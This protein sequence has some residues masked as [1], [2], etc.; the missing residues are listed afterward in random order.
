MLPYK[1]HAKKVGFSKELQA[2]NKFNL[3][4]GQAI[5]KTLFHSIGG[6]K[7]ECTRAF[8][9]TLINLLSGY[10][11]I[12]QIWVV[13]EEQP[14]PLHSGSLDLILNPN[15]D[16]TGEQSESGMGPFGIL[17][18]AREKGDIFGPAS[19]IRFTI[20]ILIALRDSFFIAENNKLFLYEYKESKGNLI[21]TN[22][23]PELPAGDHVITGDHPFGFESDISDDEVRTQFATLM[24]IPIDNG[25]VSNLFHFF[26]NGGALIYA[27]YPNTRLQSARLLV[28]ELNPISHLVSCA[29]GETRAAG[30]QNLITLRPKSHNERVTSFIYSRNLKQQIDDL[31][32]MWPV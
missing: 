9:E 23:I 16:G 19:A 1:D 28:G 30:G 32:Y 18:S 13:G 7:D 27:D 5:R 8:S 4:V 10:D 3:E 2:L 14:R 6:T 12:N 11:W 24:N 29:F 15:L 20:F 17:L 31:A 25:L 22:E 26:N 21:L